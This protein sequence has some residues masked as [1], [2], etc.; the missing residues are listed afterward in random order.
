MA[1]G[2]PVV[3]SRIEPLNEVADDATFFVDPY[4]HS[5]IAKGILSVC[6]DQTLRM[7]LIEKGRLRAK[8]F[9]WDNTAIKTLSFLTSYNSDDNIKA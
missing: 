9:T 7:K 1:S 5:D 6:R 8:E 4:N 3:C 2:V